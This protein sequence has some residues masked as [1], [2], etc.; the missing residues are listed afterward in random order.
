[1]PNVAFT[2]YKNFLIAEYSEDDVK[3]Y[4]S[5]QFYADNVSSYE[6]SS[7]SSVS[8]MID[9]ALDTGDFDVLGYNTLMEDLGRQPPIRTDSESTGTRYYMRIIDRQSGELL[10]E[11]DYTFN[12][13]EEVIEDVYKMIQ[14]GSI[15]YLVYGYT[16]EIF[17]VHPDVLGAVA[18]RSEKL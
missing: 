15:P 12:N 11:Y 4:R 2:L 5:R 17:D 13:T 14:D 3:A 6:S 8:Q 9:G 18:V 1:M 10:H 16:V 7:Q